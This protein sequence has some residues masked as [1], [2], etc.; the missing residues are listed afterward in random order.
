MERSN[1]AM[2]LFPMLEDQVTV[3]ECGFVGSFERFYAETWQTVYRAL[4][5]AVG[6]PDVA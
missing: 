3:N 5:V 1:R 4:V 6:D 2:R